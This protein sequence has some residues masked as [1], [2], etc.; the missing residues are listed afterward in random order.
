V[1]R[2]RTETRPRRSLAVTLLDGLLR[3]TFGPAPSPKVREAGAPAQRRAGRYLLAA[4]ALA[5]VAAT[6]LLVVVL[7]RSP[8]DPAPG[9]GPAAALPGLESRPPAASAVAPSAT[10]VS[11]SPTASATTRTATGQATAPAPA[12][13][14]PRDGSSPAGSTS[15]PLTASYATTAA[16]L[17]GYQMTVTVVN[18]GRTARDGWQLTVTFSRST[19]EVTDVTGA[20]ATRNG[21]VWTFIP[22]ETTTRVAAAGSVQVVFSVQGATLIDAAPQDCRID[23]SPCAGA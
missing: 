10:T 23:A 1:S 15:V 19:L 11:G 7:V 8:D 16:G 9:P 20:T 17:L 12:P 5:A 22:D 4:G 14:T 6:A 2:I 18:P 3:L 13:G 21:A